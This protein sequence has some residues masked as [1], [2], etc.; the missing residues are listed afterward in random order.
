MDINSCAARRRLLGCKLHV[1]FLVSFYQPA[2]L[3]NS[4]STQRERLI[5]VSRT[6]T[7]GVSALLKAWKW[8]KICHGKDTGLLN[9]NLLVEPRG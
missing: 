5:G 6:G 1:S 7:R 3:R 4:V 2:W 8:K 9:H